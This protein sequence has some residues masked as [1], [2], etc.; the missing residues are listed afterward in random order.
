MFQNQEPQ[1]TYLVQ[2]NF[3]K[4]MSWRFEWDRYLSENLGGLPACSAM[5]V[6]NKHTDLSN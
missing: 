3:H 2:L 1:L 4:R 6:K 5:L